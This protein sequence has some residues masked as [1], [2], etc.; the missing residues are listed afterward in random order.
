[1]VGENSRRNV[2]TKRGI[3]CARCEILLHSKI[4]GSGDG[5]YCEGCLNEMGVVDKVA[6]EVVHIP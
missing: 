6:D 2:L 5:K 3:I 1:M 4:A